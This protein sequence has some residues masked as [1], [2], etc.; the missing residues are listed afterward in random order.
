MTDPV[1]K[2]GWEGL[3]YYAA[4]GSTSW[5]L[6]TAIRD[7]TYENDMDMADVSERSDGTAVPVEYGRPVR[8]TAA[9]TFQHLMKSGD[10]TLALMIAA[11]RNGTPFGVKVLPYSGAP[12]LICDAYFSVSNPQPIGGEQ[13]L[14]FTMKKMTDADRVANLNAS[15]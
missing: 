4:A 13:V 11:A 15:S 5:T 9:L 3:I 7:V 12:G 14:T 8:R 2:V 10:A 1:K 6:L